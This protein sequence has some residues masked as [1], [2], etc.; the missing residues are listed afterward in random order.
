MPPKCEALILTAN[1]DTWERL[2]EVMEELAESENRDF[3]R[4]LG[5]LRYKLWRTGHRDKPT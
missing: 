5:Q 3:Q 1:S 2:E 4:L